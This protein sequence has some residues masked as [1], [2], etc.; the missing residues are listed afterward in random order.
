MTRYASPA[1]TVQVIGPPFDR[2]GE[3]LV[4]CY[5]ET[6]SFKSRLG[7]Q[8]DIPGVAMAIL[9]GLPRRRRS[10]RG[11]GVLTGALGGAMV[12]IYLANEYLLRH[13][14]TT[15]KA[16]GNNP[17][18]GIWREIADEVGVAMLALWVVLA[19]GRRGHAEP[20]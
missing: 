8:N 13:L 2:V 12:I 5:H 20:N 9:N 17:F 16:Y 1:G 7:G 6:I 4:R 11:V 15:I 18:N 3:D 14:S 19:L 10:F